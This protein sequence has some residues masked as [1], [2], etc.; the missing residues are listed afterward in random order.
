[1]KQMMFMCGVDTFGI[2]EHIQ[3]DNVS[4]LCALRV[5]KKAQITTR[6][7]TAKD[8]GDKGAGAET[9]ICQL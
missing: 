1:M 7:P 5:Y 8:C 6:G 3:S 9:L 2:T 4:V